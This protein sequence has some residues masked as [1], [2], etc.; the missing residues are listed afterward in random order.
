MVENCLILGL[1]QVEP[2]TK[3]RTMIGASK[4][5]TDRITFGYLTDVYVLKEFQQRGL[6]TF[7]MKCLNEVVE[8][9]PDLR[10][11]WILSGNRER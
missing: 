5:I 7:M 2:D 11:L 4:L 1:Y 9:W 10:A 3:K 8:G 6:G